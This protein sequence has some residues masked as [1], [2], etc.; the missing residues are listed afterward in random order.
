MTGGDLL[1]FSAHK[2]PEGQ[3]T[4]EGKGG[5]QGKSVLRKYEPKANSFFYSF[6][7]ID[8]PIIIGGSII[9]IWLASIIAKELG[10]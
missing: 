1:Y 6:E 10:L 2:S 3:Q 4:S 5:E 9:G 7:F 8:I